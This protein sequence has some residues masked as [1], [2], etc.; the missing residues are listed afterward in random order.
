MTFEQYVSTYGPALLRLARLLT[1]DQHRAE[2][3]VQDVLARAWSRWRRI[4]RSNQPDMY[5][6]RMLINANTSW[7]RR[8]PN[9]EISTASF[10]DRPQRGDVG[11]ETV[12]RDEMWRLIQELPG[13]Q[14]AVVALRYY[15]D[16]DDSTIAQILGCSSATV[17]THAMRALNTLRE[18]YRTL[19]TATR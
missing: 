1:G 18:R 12:A 4:A 10:A 17:R 14:R 16:F 8:R 3:L 7:W 13:R 2:D 19:A 11:S 9:R 15:E 5:V 6:R